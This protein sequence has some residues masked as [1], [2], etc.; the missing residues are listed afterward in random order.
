MYLPKSDLYKELKTLNYFTAQ[1]QPAVFKKLP[2]IIFRV[3]DNSI[4]TD[5]SNNIA[6][7]DINVTV[8]IWAESSVQ[9]SKVL[10]EVEFL[11]RK[12]YWKM[13]NSSDVPN[14]GNLYHIVSRFEK[15]I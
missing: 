12:N 5:L 11:M 15:I 13:N 1:T 3:D 9:A 6:Y 7:Q 4:N 14:E 10:D 2:A 8:D